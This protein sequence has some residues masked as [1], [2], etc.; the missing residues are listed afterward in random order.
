MSNST[1]SESTNY[2]AN[3]GFCHSKFEREFGVRF[4]LCNSLPNFF[5]FLTC[6]FNQ[7]VVYK[8]ALLLAVFYIVVVIPFTKMQRVTTFSIPDASMKNIKRSRVVQ[9]TDV[10]RESMRQNDFCL[11]SGV[12]N[13]K[14]PVTIFDTVTS[15]VPTGKWMFYINVRP[16]EFNCSTRNYWKWF[17]YSLHAGKDTKKVGRLQ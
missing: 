11:S 2:I 8:S 1:P 10:I 3:G 4:S 14:M 5:R 17:G 6:Q 13:T 12:H 9:S 15:P 7:S 16:E